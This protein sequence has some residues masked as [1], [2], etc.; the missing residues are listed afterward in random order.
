MIAVDTNI[1][2]Y[3]YHSEAPQHA[4]A[5]AALK[6]LAEGSVAWGIPVFAIG[7]FLRVVTHRLG[8]L[9][10]PVNGAEAMRAIDV[11]VESPSA[12]VLLPG[13]RFLPL[14]RDLILGGRVRGDLVFDAQIVA[15]CL[16]HGATT[17][18]TEDRDF[19]RFSGITVEGIG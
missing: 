1:L 5:R 3:A 12:R 11:L 4:T 8:P 10:R 13:R 14:L 17:I 9:R 19:R 18:L 6:E 2:V 15:V 7:E 16:E